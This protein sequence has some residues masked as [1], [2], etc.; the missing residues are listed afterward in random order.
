[1]GGMPLFPFRIVLK[2][3]DFVHRHPDVIAGLARWILSGESS[4]DRDCYPLASGG[5]LE[6]YSQEP[7]IPFTEPSRSTEC[8]LH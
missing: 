1:M 4:H 7:E 8:E 2:H 3:L 6:R 5:D